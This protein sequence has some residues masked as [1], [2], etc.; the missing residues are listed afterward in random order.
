MILVKKNE[1]LW[2][3]HFIDDFSTQP[4]KIDYLAYLWENFDYTRYAEIAFNLDK[5]FITV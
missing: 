1:K 4:A 3:L 2:G 5:F